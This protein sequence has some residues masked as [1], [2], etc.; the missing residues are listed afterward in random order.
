MKS[1]G[2][3]LQL[4]AVNSYT[5]PTVISGGMVTLGTPPTLAAAGAG[6]P[7]V[8]FDPSNSANYTLSGGSVTQLNNLTV[9]STAASVGNA[10]VQS[11]HGAPS[12]TLSNP[13]FN[14][15]TTL[16]FSGAQA[17]GGLNL[18]VM[19]SS[20]YT[21]L[22]EQ[23]VGALGNYYLLGTNE[24]GVTNGGL[25]FGYRANGDFT[26]AQYANDLDATVPGYTVRRSP[27]K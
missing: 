15:R 3:T 13:A 18:S 22:A 8:W 20:S 23:A 19:N 1:G 10:T 9:A 26:L 6:N 12:L 21:I 4:T 27:A 14:G 24:S 11:G 7:L 16:H 2:S 17:L 5:G 25:H